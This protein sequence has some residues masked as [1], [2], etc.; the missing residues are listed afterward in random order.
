MVRIIFYLTFVFIQLSRFQGVENYLNDFK[1]RL[2]YWKTIMPLVHKWKAVRG[3]GS[4]EGHVASV[5]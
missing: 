2:V 5:T 3:P 4:K 1:E